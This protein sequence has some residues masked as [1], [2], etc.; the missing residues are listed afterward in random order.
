MGKYTKT[1]KVLIAAKKEYEKALNK[2]KAFQK[3]GQM[4][5]N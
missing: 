1:V 5:S 4:H 3:S 2:A